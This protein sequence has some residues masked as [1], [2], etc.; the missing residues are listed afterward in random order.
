MV[1]R[2]TQREGTSFY[3]NDYLDSSDGSHQSQEDDYDYGEQAHPR[4]E[5]ANWFGFGRRKHR[6]HKKHHR[7]KHHKYRFWKKHHDGLRQDD[8]QQPQISGDSNDFNDIKN[9]I[10]PNQQED[11]ANFI[12]NVNAVPQQF[13]FDVDAFVANNRLTDAAAEASSSAAKESVPERAF[14]EFRPES[15]VADPSVAL[16]N[17]S[18]NAAKRGR[19]DILTQHLKAIA[20][21]IHL[22][23]SSQNDPFRWTYSASLMT[24]KKHVKSAEDEDNRFIDNFYLLNDGKPAAPP[25]YPVKSKQSEALA[26][27][28]LDIELDRK[29]RA[30]NSA[31]Y[32]PEAALFSN[33][34][35]LP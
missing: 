21:K 31:L 17:L 27:L 19:R 14:Y 16:S 8:V 13:D 26:D 11:I 32:S 28:D 6:K 7:R 34:Q 10:Q 20:N 24:D 5:T 29:F 25:M 3:H 33:K 23:P 4:D 35:Q 1:K 18:P 9:R 2:S 15:R 22:Y 12:R 30:L